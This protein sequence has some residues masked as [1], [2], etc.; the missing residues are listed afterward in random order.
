VIGSDGAAAHGH[1][2]VTVTTAAVG[3]CAVAPP[4]DEWGLW[5]LF[6]PA[7]LLKRRARGACR[8]RLAN[9]NC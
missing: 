3:G 2:V 7:W 6:A 4:S 5:G 1:A 9:D 8:N